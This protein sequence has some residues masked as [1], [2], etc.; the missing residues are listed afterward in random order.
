M[1]AGLTL[2]LGGRRVGG[3]LAR[4]RSPVPGSSSCGRTFLL[5]LFFGL[6]LE[7]TRLMHQLHEELPP[8]LVVGVGYGVDDPRVQAE[9]RNRDLTPS[10]GV[11]MAPPSVEWTPTLPEDQRFGHADAFLRCLADEVMPLI[12]GRY[13]VSG[14]ATL[15]GLYAMLTRTELFGRYIL[16]SPGIWWD[17]EWLLRYEEEVAAT[18]EDLQA[19]LFLG[20][21]ALEETEALPWLAAFRMITNLGVMRARLESR[22]YPSLGID[23]QVFA[24]ESHTSVV[25]AVLTRGLR[26]LLGAPR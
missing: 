25:P 9:L 17:Q 21:G 11:S 26:Q 10:A 23:T 18:R 4:S 22:A 20:V 8:L 6:A 15:F 1:G 2:L 16:A 14:P 24:D 12:R 19:S 7:M 5:S 13:P 3:R